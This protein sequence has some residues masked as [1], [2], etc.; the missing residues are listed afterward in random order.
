MELEGQ[1]NS[2]KNVKAQ[3]LRAGLIVADG[4]WRSTFSDKNR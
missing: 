1:L 4:K 3:I 2:K